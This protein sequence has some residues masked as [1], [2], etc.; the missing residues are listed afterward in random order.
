[1]TE[2]KTQ[3]AERGVIKDKAVT[4]VPV[5]LVIPQLFVN[6]VDWKYIRLK[7][8]V[9]LASCSVLKTVAA[10]KQYEISRK[11][12]LGP[13]RIS[14]AQCYIRFPYFGLSS[15]I[16]RHR[17]PQ[18]HHQRGVS[19]EGRDLLHA[20]LTAYRRCLRFRSMYLLSQGSSS[21]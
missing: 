7:T 2:P 9:L 16:L 19:L 11:C 20:V 8:K 4:Q 10:R 5:I 3:V 21:K 12:D 6:T 14:D 1:M 15:R 13:R 18:H 17:P